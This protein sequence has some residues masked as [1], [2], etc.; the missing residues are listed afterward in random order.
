MTADSLAMLGV[1]RQVA[2][3]PLLSWRQS[4]PVSGPVQAYLGQ[5]SLAH[6]FGMPAAAVLAVAYA[7]GLN[8]YVSWITWFA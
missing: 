5:I 7:T 8:L 2:W 1:L 3:S 4:Q 6:V